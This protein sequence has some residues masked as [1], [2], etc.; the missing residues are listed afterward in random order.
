MNPALPTASPAY[1]PDR[2]LA[3][4]TVDNAT[5]Q[6]STYR[7]GNPVQTNGATSYY[8]V[9]VSDNLLKILVGK[10]HIN[11]RAQREVDGIIAE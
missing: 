2:P 3:G 1:G 5:T 8:G 7:R 11:Y 6:G 4:D 9:G 10:S